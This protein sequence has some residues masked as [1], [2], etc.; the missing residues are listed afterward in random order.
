MAHH[1]KK[2]VN[3][4]E[5][6]KISQQLK[7]SRKKIVLCHGAFDLIHPGHIRHFQSAKKH[8]D[9]L[10]VT[11]TADKYMKKG[12]GRPIFN[13]GLRAEVL[14]ALNNVDF[15]AIVNSESAIEI[16]NS[17]KPDF[18]FKGP[19]YKDRKINAKVP[20]KLD[21]EKK[22]VEHWGG[23]LMFTADEITFS[24]SKLINHYLDPYPPKTKQ[25]FDG[26]KQKYSVDEIIEQL[27][28]LKSVKVLIIGDTIIDQYHYCTPMGKSSKEPV[29]VNRFLHDESFTGG[30]LAS[31]NH[32]SA[33]SD[34]VQMVTVLGKQQTFESFIRKKLYNPVRPN[35]F[36]RE[37]T[38]TYVNRRFLDSVTNQKV[39]Q[40]TYMNNTPISGTL[41]KKIISYLGKQIP[42]SDLVIVNDFGHGMI[43]KN[44]IETICTQ[45]KYLTLNVQANSANY[46]FNVVTKFPSANF[47]CI[48]EQE[49]RLATH[50]KY[51]DIPTLVRILG[52]QTNFAEMI[53]TRGKDGSLSYSKKNDQLIETPACV[54][55]TVDRV[56]AGDALF[57]IT[58][59]CMYADMDRAL[60]SFIG[61]VAGALQAQ[62]VGNKEQIKFA[63]LTKFITRLLK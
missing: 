19:D 2:I 12:P 20:R 1:E 45:A 18:Y 44:I 40:I 59:P 41:E 5:L 42:K 43:T 55:K 8:G 32:V 52:K 10:I 46:G 11:I 24:S 27:V 51:S 36:Y 21:V 57:A 22:A 4:T 28:Q 39:F 25:Y 34:Q 16:I 53:I 35:F 62:V 37:D 56:G 9:I 13:E 7:K 31:A 61:N 26:L 6:A 54:D 29:I 60:V 17:I 50:D 23:K 14:A 33:L 49:L 30:V 47:V 3:L 63:D 38:N 58:S 48:D 15:V